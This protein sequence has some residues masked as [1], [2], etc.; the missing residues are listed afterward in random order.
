MKY[1]TKGGIGWFQFPQKT[2][3]TGQKF[4]RIG[5]EDPVT[6]T[7]EQLAGLKAH[8]KTCVDAEGKPRYLYDNIIEEVP[9]V[10][11]PAPITKEEQA[12]G[13]GKKKVEAK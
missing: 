10:Q 8:I 7:A 13:K 4:K 12:R 9:D 2:P 3:R 6:L 1:K 5:P 11:T